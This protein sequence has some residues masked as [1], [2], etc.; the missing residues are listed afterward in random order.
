MNLRKKEGN[1][2]SKTRR[3]AGGRRSEGPTNSTGEGR[4]I[5]RRSGGEGRGLQ[6][7][8]ER[9]ANGGSRLATIAW[10][11][12]RARGEQTG[13]SWKKE[14]WEGGFLERL[15]MREA[16][17]GKLTRNQN[18][19]AP[20]IQGG[21]AE[22]M[23]SG[24]RQ[25]FGACRGAGTALEEKFGKPNVLAYPRGTESKV[26]AILS[27]GGMVALSDTGGKEDSQSVNWG[28]LALGEKER[29]QDEF[30]DNFYEMGGRATD[31]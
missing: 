16:G 5:W 17:K 19:Y 4:K 29:T 31:A 24:A 11:E 18:F 21:Q 25:V 9:Y 1:K 14:N 22:S 23:G 12:V 13:H 7:K 30:G 10:Q 6:E 20:R 3:K 15:A 26:E 28:K 2:R 8:K 27:H